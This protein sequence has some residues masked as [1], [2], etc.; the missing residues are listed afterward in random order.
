MIKYSSATAC[1]VKLSIDSKRFVMQI[2]DNGNGLD[3]NIK[4]NGS[5]LR[6][7][8]TRAAELSGSLDINSACGKGMV[9]TMSLPVPFAV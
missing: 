3:G 1:S 8:Q 7:M 6:N 9:I 5:G 4:G 2:A